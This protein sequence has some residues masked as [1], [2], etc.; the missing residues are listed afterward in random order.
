ME[1]RLTREQRRACTMLKSGETYQQVARRLHRSHGFVYNAAVAGGA[2][3]R[4]TAIQQKQREHTE[5][6][7]RLALL[8]ARLADLGTTHTIDVLEGLRSIPD[9]SVQTV[10]TSPPYN[11]GRPYGGDPRTDRMAHLAY[12]GFMLQVISELARVLK[13]GGVIALQVGSTK[14][15]SGVLKPLDVVLWDYLEMAGLTAQSR[16]AWPSIHGLTPKRRLA[17]RYETVM[18][19][20]KGPEPSVFNPTVA[21][22]PQKHITKRAFHGPRKGELTCNP[23][24]A[25]PSNVWWDVPHVGH[26]RGRVDHPAQFSIELARRIVLLYS[27]PQDIILDCFSG[28]GTTQLAAFQTGR[29]FVGFDLYYADLRESRMQDAVPDRVSVLPGVTTENSALWEAEAR[30]VNVDAQISLDL[31]A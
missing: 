4:E 30:R 19:F 27:L 5:T 21:R 15:D 7:Q 17:E 10:C 6:T 16:V 22:T 28:S 20:S 26:N 12:L 9:C 31:S 2:R 13:P 1:G 25:F 23:L 8:E 14:M 3:R 11:V 18:I 29:A 24:G